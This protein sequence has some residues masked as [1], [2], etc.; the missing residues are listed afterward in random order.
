MFTE[1]SAE[2]AIDPELL[3]PEATAPDPKA[4]RNNQCDGEA[5][6]TSQRAVDLWLNYVHVVAPAIYRTFKVTVVVC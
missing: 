6:F 2:T 4:Q 3:L 1:V 5:S